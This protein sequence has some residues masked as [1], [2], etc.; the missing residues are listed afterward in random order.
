MTPSWPGR[1][2]ET[3][4]AAGETGDSTL[5]APQSPRGPTSGSAHLWSRFFQRGPLESAGG[6]SA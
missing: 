3:A 5:K 6:E 4:G 2:R 1:Q